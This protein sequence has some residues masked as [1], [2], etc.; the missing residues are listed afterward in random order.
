MTAVQDSRARPLRRRLPALSALAVVGV[1]AV[2]QLVPLASASAGASAATSTTT[3][4]TTTTSSPVP[5]SNSSGCLASRLSKPGATLEYMKAGGD[6]GGYI[7]ELPTRYDGRTAMPV[8]LDLHGYGVSAADM[9]KI[10]ELGTIGN[11]DGF[12]TVTPQVARHLPYWTTGFKS[13]D[14]AFLRGV[15][16]RVESTLCVDENRLFVTG[17]SNG[18]IMASVLACVDAAQVA[19]I[20]PVSG[21]AN[22]ANCSPSRPVPVVAFHG[23]ADPLLPYTGGLS[24]EAYNLP[25]PPGSKGNISRLLGNNVPQSTTGPSVPKRTAAWATRDG[26]A[27]TSTTRVFAKNVALISYACPD[28]ATVS[29][30]RIRGGG[31]TWPGSVLDSKSN[32]LGTTTMAISA[33]KI[34]WN[35]FE[36][37]PLRP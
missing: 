14:V 15:I 31:H 6:S 21:I 25:L 27:S 35:F 5:S 8:V 37:H 22:P 26:C 20:A 18:A 23:T 16:S 1:S 4:P 3:P 11:R 7:L 33:D 19:A 30:Y 24:A 2:A 13:K 10:T 29:L 34:I 9:L 32:T 17:Y 36:A 12:I 28:G